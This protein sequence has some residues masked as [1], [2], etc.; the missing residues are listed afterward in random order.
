MRPIVCLESVLS[1]SYGLHCLRSPDTCQSLGVLDP[2]EGRA[3]KFLPNST[4]AHSPALV[5]ASTQVMF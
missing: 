4:G 1:C 5:G 3:R 2:L